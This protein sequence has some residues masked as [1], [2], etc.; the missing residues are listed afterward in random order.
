MP[1][2]RA[3]SSFASKAGPLIAPS[4]IV[5]LRFTTRPLRTSPATVI[6]TRPECIAFKDVQLTPPKTI[7]ASRAFPM[8]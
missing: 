5:F 2:P 8:R 6:R 4:C 1:E 7:A 3:V